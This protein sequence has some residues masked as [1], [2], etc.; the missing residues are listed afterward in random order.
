VKLLLDQN[1]SRHLVGQLRDLFPESEH[2]SA[3]GLD[4]ATDQEI[5]EYAGDHDLGIVC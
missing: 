4:D 5:W 3:V 1:L 2:V